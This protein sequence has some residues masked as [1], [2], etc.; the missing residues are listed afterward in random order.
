MFLPFALRFIFFL[1]GCVSPMNTYMYSVFSLLIP[2]S[3][4][5]FFFSL[6]VYLCCRCCQCCF[7]HI[8]AICVMHVG[9]RA[10]K[11]ADCCSFSVSN[12]YYVRIKITFLCLTSDIILMFQIETARRCVECHC[13]NF[14][15][16][17]SRWLSV[18]RTDIVCSPFARAVS[19]LH[20]NSPVFFVS[21]LF[22]YVRWEFFTLKPTT[23]SQF[24]K[25]ILDMSCKCSQI[26]KLCKTDRFNA[27]R[28]KTPAKFH[29]FI[30]FLTVPT[31]VMAQQKSSLIFWWMKIWQYLFVSN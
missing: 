13:A 23:V 18:N 12:W 17:S 8:F 19:H 11:L 3:N 21:C 26:N 9:F 29:V 1:F 4:C 14:I 2:I 27:N 15:R 22:I 5:C 10:Y 30:D 20:K 16:V 25:F 6:F 28:K 7:S 24:N 31:N